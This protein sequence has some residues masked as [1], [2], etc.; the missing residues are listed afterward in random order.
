M[1][2][3]IA[4]ADDVLER[5]LVDRFDRRAIE[6][7]LWFSLTHRSP[8]PTAVS[9]SHH[10]ARL[11]L[12]GPGNALAAAHVRQLIIRDRLHLAIELQLLWFPLLHTPP[13][14]TAATRRWDDAVL[15]VWTW[16]STRHMLQHLLVEWP[17]DDLIELELFGLLFL[18]MTLGVGARR[19]IP[20][21]D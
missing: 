3:R 9:G 8:L 12:D 6:L 15:V 7:E 4:T 14:E 11:R 20:E 2:R 21:L 17:D 5:L 16:R 19:P 13:L 1:L 18:H 10:D